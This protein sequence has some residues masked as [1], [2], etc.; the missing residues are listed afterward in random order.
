MTKKEFLKKL[1]SYLKRNGV[2]DAP[3]DVNG[4]NWYIDVDETKN[5]IYAGP[6]V[7]GKIIN[8]VERDLNYYEG[9]SMNDILEDLYLSI[10]K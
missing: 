10:K 6:K 2:E 1:N 9:W 4:E 7:N 5:V 8:K 3:F